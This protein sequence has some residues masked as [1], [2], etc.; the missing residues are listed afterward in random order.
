VITSVD[1]SKADKTAT[2]VTET[3]ERK[4]VELKLSDKMAVDAHLKLGDR[5]NLGKSPHGEGALLTK[6]GKV[7]AHMR[8]VSDEGLSG[9]AS[10][11]D[12]P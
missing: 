10:L 11:T 2:L 4:S 1:Y 12:K 9:S 5:V 3:P 6:Q 8:N 7:I